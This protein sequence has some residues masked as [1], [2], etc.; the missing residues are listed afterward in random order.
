MS[1][2]GE[3]G[4]KQQSESQQVIE[5]AINYS[6]WSYLDL[7]KIWSNIYYYTYGG[8]YSTPKSEFD[9]QLTSTNSATTE[10]PIEIPS[11]KVEEVKSPI[12]IE[13]PKESTPV[14]SRST[15]AK[16]ERVPKSPKSKPIV[17]RP[18]ENTNN[19]NTSISN[20]SPLEKQ[21]FA[22]LES[23]ASGAIVGF[24]MGSALTWTQ[25][26]TAPSN[27]SSSALEQATKQARDV[28]TK[29]AEDAMTQLN[30]IRM[31]ESA[32]YIARRGVRCF[33]DCIFFLSHRRAN[34]SPISSL[35]PSNSGDVRSAS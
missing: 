29:A 28:A 14:I 1:E 7:Y 8:Y 3:K 33:I 35:P 9:Q 12:L 25:I 13:S 6:V 27:S 11:D 15:S 19:A 2:E 20:S 21:I 30:P 18:S 34:Q 23:T 5:G 22:T 4:D 10:A 31:E 26:T 24:V 32:A 17:I 16:P